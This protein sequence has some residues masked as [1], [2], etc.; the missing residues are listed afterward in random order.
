MGGDPPADGQQ[1]IGA[2]DFTERSPAI[3]AVLA[4]GVFPKGAQRCDLL[5]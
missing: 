2:G 5:L 4:L 3:L 1:L